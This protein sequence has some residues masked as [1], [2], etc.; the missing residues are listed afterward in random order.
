M[1]SQFG[2]RLYK[3]PHSTWTDLFVTC[4]HGRPIGLDPIGLD[5][6]GLDPESKNNIITALYESIHVIVRE[7]TGQ[8]G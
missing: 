5:P 1:S 2:P 8:L 6:I 4:F 7:Y 3:D